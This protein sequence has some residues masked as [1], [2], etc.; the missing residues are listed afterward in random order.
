MQKQAYLISEQYRKQFCPLPASSDD[1]IFFDRVPVELP[2]AEVFPKI[3][4]HDR[5][6]IGICEEGGGL[7]LSEGVFSSVSKG[8]LIFIAPGQCHYSRSLKQDALCICRFAYINAG[9]VERLIM[10]ANSGNKNKSDFRSAE[11]NVP[12][13]IHAYEHPKAASLLSGIMDACKR[14]DDSGESLVSLSLSMFLL[15]IQRFFGKASKDAL[16]RHGADNAVTMICEYLS[17]NYS[18]SDTAQEL[19]KKCHLSESQLR[20]RF[21]AVHGIPPITY[22]N[23]LRCKIA[24]EL[25]SRTRIPISEIAERIGYTAP[26]DFY[27]AFRKIYG[28]SPSSYRINNSF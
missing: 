18:N 7:F 2:Y 21:L 13:V 19:A 4:Y 8:D 11:K 3:H 14:N 5:Y 20:R 1:I 26:S 25:L 17:L 6:E 23:L 9:I 16:N 22:R 12:P 15:E 10:I 28:I 27:R 24:A